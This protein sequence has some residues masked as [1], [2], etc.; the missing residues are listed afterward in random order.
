VLAAFRMVDCKQ[1][2]FHLRATRFDA[3]I[4]TATAL[5]AVFI[6]VEFCILIGVILSFVLYVPRAAQ[7]QLTEFTLTGNHEV[8]ERAGVDP[9][10]GPILVFQLEGGLSFGAAAE[11]ECHL[12]RIESTIQ[13]KTHVV[14]RL[15]KRARNPDA[16]FLGL[17]GKFQLRLQERHVAV[18][19]CGVRSDLARGL[20]ASGLEAQLGPQQVVAV[21]ASP[22]TSTPDGIARA[23]AILG[24]AAAKHA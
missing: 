18:I 9:P 5:A 23:G 11:L 22:D 17:V 14:V 15:L 24:H 3:I 7:V 13:S 4:V 8:R 1:L 2:A 6:S 19:L 10:A 21:T 12:A 16:A 20:R